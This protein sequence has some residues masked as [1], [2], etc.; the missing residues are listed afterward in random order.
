MGLHFR[1]K[2]VLKIGFMGFL[3]IIFEKRYFRQFLSSISYI[4]E[5]RLNTESIVSKIYKRF[6]DYI[7]V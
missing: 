5:L 2:K 3:K 4:S 1:R 7:L 6:I